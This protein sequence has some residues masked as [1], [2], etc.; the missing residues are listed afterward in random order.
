MD[1]KT[2][3]PGEGPINPKIVFVGESPGHEELLALKPFVGASGKLL[4][5]LLSDVGISRSNCWVTNVC[6]YY[7]TPNRKGEKQIPFAVRAHTSGVDL[8]KELEN[9]RKELLHLQP[10]I[11]VP[12]GG[13]ALWA[14]TGKSGIEDWRGSILSGVGGIKTVGSYHPAHIL[15]SGGEAGGYWAKNI[16]QTDLVRVKK[17]SEFKDIRLPQRSLKVISSPHEFKE[18]LDR[19]K[20]YL[21]PAIDIEAWQC[22]PICVGI[23]FTPYD[24]I[25]IPL[26]NCFGVS[27]IPT[28]SLATL[29]GMLAEFLANHDIVGQ[30][31]GYDR[32][33]LKRFGFRIKKI[34]SDTMLKA[35]AMYPEL[36]KNLAYLTSVYTEEPFYKNEGMYEGEVSDLLLGCARDACCTKEVDI[37]TDED[38]KDIGTEQYYKNFLLPLQVV[39]AGIENKGINLDS[40]FRKEVILKYIEMDEKLRYEIFKLAGHPVNVNSPKQVAKLL[41]EEW[42]LPE[43]KGVGEEVLSAIL[44]TKYMENKPNY[45][46]GIELILEDRKV[47]KTL[48]SYAYA[49]PD[50]DGRM[51]TSYFLCLDTGRSSTSQQDPPIRP[52]IEYHAIE[53]G[54]KTKKHQSRGMAFQTITKH[55]DIG[56]DIRKM[57]VPDPGHVFL[58]ADS[59]QAET[60]VVFLLAT[61]YEA[62]EL[63]NKID[64]HAL[65]TS[66][67]FG[68]DE[69]KY[70]K[71]ILGYEV[72]E[73]FV[74][75]TLRHAGHLGARAKRAATTVNTDARKYKVN[76]SI[77]EGKA[78][79]A[80]RTFHAMQPKIRSVFHNGIIN[81]LERDRFLIAPVPH[82]IKASQGG[83]RIF[84]ERW[85]DELFR[86]AYSSLPQ[87]IVSENTK[88]AA[89][90]I[91][92]CEEHEIQGRAPWIDILIESHDALM[93]Q[94]PIEREIEAAQILKEELEKPIDFRNCSLPRGLLSIPCEVEE[95]YNYK[96][97]KKFKWK[98]EEMIND[99]G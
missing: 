47:R 81:C 20:G 4:N 99:K 82:G 90:R 87:R 92:G 70:S 8:T 44:D 25:C 24:G 40:E 32:D 52:D 18:F 57:L 94:V 10:N 23:A 68:G 74:G 55:G 59:E 69:A 79:D 60:R 64:Y 6:K 91:K 30:N 13:T 48:S 88:G 38:L 58:Q 22:I 67:F 54:K 43:R 46:K 37:N 98:I 31:I 66:W 51:R 56:A 12:L 96:D 16:L 34:H 45:A 49:L 7:V 86:Q 36:P 76:I 9:L 26:W 61:D 11:I 41:Y 80:L 73:R 65:T 53:D 93:V 19:N 78:E 28:S 71:K 27:S 63:L 72:P 2:Y 14:T 95:G 33:K 29:Y 85:G 3:V 42:K 84:F 39:Y 17:Q 62:L 97:L 83:K 75:K 77:T 21:Y 5:S 1:S 50:F 35:F 15:Y 89:L